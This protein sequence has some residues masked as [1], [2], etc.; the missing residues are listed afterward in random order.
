MKGV[1]A[2]Q[3]AHLDGTPLLL[4]EE[5]D[6]EGEQDSPG[7][8]AGQALQADA[9]IAGNPQQPPHLL[10]CQGLLIREVSQRVLIL[11]KSGIC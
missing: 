3:R 9:Q 6:E 1:P 7:Q 11:H 8:T 2:H 4:M 5:V 10:C